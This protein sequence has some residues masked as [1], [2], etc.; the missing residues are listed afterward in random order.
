MAKLRSSKTVLLALAVLIAVVSSVARAEDEDRKHCPTE[1]EWAT[2]IDPE[3]RPFFQ[4]FSEAEIWA[5]GPDGSAIE[6]MAMFDL[7]YS[8]LTH[9]YQDTP[10]YRDEYSEV[11][12]LLSK[13]PWSRE[14]YGETA[15]R[16]IAQCMSG[17]PQQID[18]A[19][20]AFEKGYLKPL[21][22]L[23]NEPNFRETLQFLKDNC[24]K[25]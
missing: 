12:E 6:G 18:C 8:L 2:T 14:R 5:H 23:I 13:E 21:D 16:E 24:Q 15:L 19:Q 25:K 1:R 7:L 9:A 11:F 20:M 22:D 10:D 4:G 17:S 3:N